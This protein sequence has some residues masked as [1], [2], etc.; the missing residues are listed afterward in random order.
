MHKPSEAKEVVPKFDKFM[1]MLSAPHLFGVT[2][3]VSPDRS[4]KEPVLGTSEL[5]TLD[6]SGVPSDVPPDGAHRGHVFVLRQLG[7]SDVPSDAR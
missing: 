2:S 1:L 7:T 4:Y 6:L 3:D 5:G